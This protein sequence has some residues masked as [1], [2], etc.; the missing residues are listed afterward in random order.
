M[1]VAEWHA[2][3]DSSGDE[4]VARRVGPDPLVHSGSFGDTAHD[5]GSAVEVQASAV[6][7][8]EDR[9]RDSL[10]GREVDGSGGARCEGEGDGRPYVSVWVWA[11]LMA[12]RA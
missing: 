5:A 8:G 3:V 7:S 12:S 11:R 2:G 9:S 4:R 10:S 6:G 1:A